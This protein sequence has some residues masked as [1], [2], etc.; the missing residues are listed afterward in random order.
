MIYVSIILI[1]TGVSRGIYTIY[2]KR[3]RFVP[4]PRIQQENARKYVLEEV[5]ENYYPEAKIMKT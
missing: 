3:I 2:A 1:N 5:N 4:M